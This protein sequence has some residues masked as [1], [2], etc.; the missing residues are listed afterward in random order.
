MSLPCRSSFFFFLPLLL[1]GGGWVLGAPALELVPEY[2]A[3]Q[4][5]MAEGL[6]GVTRVKLERLLAETTFSEAQR[7]K[8]LQMQVEA[9]MRVGDLAAAQR[10]VK[11]LEAPERSFWLGHLALR[12]GDSVAAEKALAAYPPDGPRHAQVQL[13]LAYAFAGQNRQ[14]MARRT[15]KDLRDHPDTDVAYEARLLFN[16]LELG[17]DKPKVVLDRLGREVG[18]DARVQFLRARALFETGDAVKAESVL[19]DL[20]A[21]EGIGAYAHDA[22]TMQLALVLAKSDGP[23]AEDLLVTFGNSFSSTVKGAAVDT[24][25]WLEAFT[26]LERLA[27]LDGKDPKLLAAA[28][29]WA[30]DDTV[31]ERHGHA[32]FLVAQ[33]L[34][35]AGKD[36]SAI[37]FLEA[38]IGLYPQHGRGAEAIQLAMQ[39]HG[40]QGADERVLALAN[41]WRGAAG[42]SA[43]PIIEFLTGAIYFARGETLRAVASFSRAAEVDTDSVRRRRSLYNAAM[44]AAKVGQVALLAP[45]L[46]Q[47]QAAPPAEVGKGD[48]VS[49]EDLIL[50]KALSL[51]AAGELTAAERE[52]SAFVQEKAQLAHPRLAEAWMALA[53]L[54]LL[55]Q[56]PRV[57]SA[58]KALLTA[59]QAAVLASDKEHLHYL[60]IWLEEARDDILKV[61]EEGLIFIKLWPASPKLPEVH[62]KVAEAYYRV[63]NLAGARTYFELVALKWPESPYADTALYFA[64]RAAL[65]IGSAESQNAAISLFEQVAERAGPLAFDARVQQAAA[66]RLQGSHAEALLLLDALLAEA[67]AARRP[68]LLC[69]KAEILISTGK[70]KAA[71]DLLSPKVITNDLAYSWRARMLYLRAMALRAEKRLE[72]ALEACYDAVELGLDPVAPAATPAE[73]EWLYRAGFL[74]ISLME[75]SQQWEPAANMAERLSRTGAPLAEEAGAMASRIR[76]QHF[77]WDGKK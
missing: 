76:L 72:E 58:E 46:T 42:P 19:R 59:A 25:F 63:Q 64:G 23:A 77:I 34:H 35:R 7:Q 71:S 3:A 27:E 47:L 70:N 4:R 26:A 48:G 75:E 16:E 74:A 51:A 49:A 8:L 60:R 40:A 12:T 17:G 56:P 11:D 66:K 37:G 33:L 50:D 22:A 31:P 43:E 1:A 39:I 41:Q 45:L 73:F 36:S 62:M 52:L 67:P 38:L 21:T 28:L 15:I 53:E 18:R 68:G 10:W 69:D 29:I 24:D 20:L 44:A 32:L 13:A 14:A 5:A 6:P 2:L 65:S 30:S 9:C 55:D 54:A 61:A 57:E